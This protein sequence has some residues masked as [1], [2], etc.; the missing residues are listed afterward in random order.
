MSKVTVDVG[1]ILSPDVLYGE[2]FDEVQ[3]KHVFTDTKTFVDCVP[4]I[5]SEEIVKLYLEKKSSSSFDLFSFVNEY[6]HFPYSP[7]TNFCSD[8]NISTVDHINRLW[9][10]LTRPADQTIEGSSRIALPYPYVVPGGRFGEIFYWDSYFTMLGLSVLPSKKSLIQNM[11][12]NFAYL[13]DTYGFIPNGNRTYFLS[14]S[15][16]PFFA[17]MIQLLADLDSNPS[18]I[19]KKYSKQLYEEYQFWMSG[20]DQ[21]SQ[22]NSY[23]KVC[24]SESLL[25]I[26]NTKEF[27]LACCSFIRWKNC[28]SLLGSI[29]KGKSRIVSQRSW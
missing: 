29:I 23:N 14:R 27:I 10:I 15:Q 12:D 6:F 26:K 16:P 19:Y 11:I 25:L 7:K 22:E 9:D 28:K 2:L 4:K 13:I 17:C 24:F 20:K 18:N 21:L 1:N 5:P 3:L 8:I